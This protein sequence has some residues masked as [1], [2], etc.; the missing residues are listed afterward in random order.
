MDLSPSVLLGEIE[1]AL[2]SLV[3]AGIL[4]VNN[5]EMLLLLPTLHD[6]RLLPQFLP[7]SN[8]GR[9]LV[10]LL[11]PKMTAM[12]IWTIQF[13]TV[14]A[15]VLVPATWMLPSLELHGIN[16]HTVRP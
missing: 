12:S 3:P 13:R 4:L 2:S 10:Q 11:K 9:L 16:V 8:L 1:V 14:P 15:L 7:M 5:G 6:H